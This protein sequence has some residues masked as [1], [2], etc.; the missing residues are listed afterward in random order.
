MKRR[1][2]ENRWNFSMSEQACP[3]YLTPNRNLVTLRDYGMDEHYAEISLLVCPD[4]DTKWLR[5]L[6]EAEGFTASGRWYLGVVSEEAVT[7]LT[8]GNASSILEGLD[9]YFLGGSYYGGRIGRSS[10]NIHGK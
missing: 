7:R 8:A 10:G 9:W 5:Y 6:L 3:C 2:I 4:C 1:A